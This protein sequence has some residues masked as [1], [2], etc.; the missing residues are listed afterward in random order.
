MEAQEEEQASIPDKDSLS[1]A[2]LAA[3]QPGAQADK[4]TVPDG[5]SVQPTYVQAGPGKASPSTKAGGALQKR[6]LGSPSN[7]AAG[8]LPIGP[9]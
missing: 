9:G 1:W 8:R 7:D 2:S 3:Y 5:I 6:K 4:G